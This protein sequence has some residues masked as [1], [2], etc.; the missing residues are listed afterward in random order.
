MERRQ[1]LK[2][3]GGFLLVCAGAGLGP[4]LLR[5]RRVFGKTTTLMGTIGEI[6]VVHD[7]ASLAHRAIDRAFEELARLEQR[8]SYFREGS[9]IG[10]INR[11][12]F[13][14]EVSIGEET[15]DLIARSLYW[16]QVT[17]G[18]F[19]PGLGKVTSIWDVKHRTEPPPDGLWRRLAGR[20]FFKSIQLTR[21]ESVYGVRLLSEDVRLDLGG[22]AKGYAAD[23]AVAALAQEGIE[24]ALVTLGGDIAS[25]GG[26]SKEQAWR[27]GIRDPLQPSQIASV[28]SLRNQAVATSGNYEQFFVSKGGLYH[29]L[30]DPT[31]A[32]PGGGGFRSLTIIGNSCRDADALA[33][34]LFFFSDEETRRTLEDHTDGFEAVRLGS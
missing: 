19:E 23:R 6:R 33:T 28:L 9:D 4:I 25:L 26:K 14:E 30:I 24:Q 2:L 16:S 3:G 32:R 10:V 34:G 8:F 21:H 22:I 20:S 29:H 17:G 5:N 12:A 13:R 27:V 11:R 18:Y 31:L 1:F 15:A 7:D